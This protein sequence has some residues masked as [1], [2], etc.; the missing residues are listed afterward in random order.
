MKPLKEKVKFPKERL[1]M[2]LGRMQR[3]VS[4]LKLGRMEK[5]SEY[6][7]ASS[8]VQ[9]CSDLKPLEPCPHRL[10]R[11]GEHITG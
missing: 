1:H 9:G 5:Q 3:T 6:F 11:Q 4:W 8:L 2:I 10:N 7:P